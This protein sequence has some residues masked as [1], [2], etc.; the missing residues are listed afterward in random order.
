M[1]QLKPSFLS[2]FFIVLLSACSKPG[3]TYEFYVFGTLVELEIYSNSKEQADSASTQIQKSFNTLHKIWHAWEQGGLL[4]KINS[5]IAAGQSIKLEPQVLEFLQTIKNLSLKSEGYFNPGIGRLVALWGFHADTWRGPPPSY[6]EIRRFIEPAITMQS[7]KFKY[8]ELVT[9]D[10]R[11]A[12]DF[13]GVV[14]GY[15]LALAGKI[16]KEQG[17]KNAAVNAGGDLLVFGKKNSK[18]WNVGIKSPGGVI[19]TVKLEDGESIVSSG[20]YERKFTWQGKL[21]HHLINP[22][23]GQPARGVSAVTVIAKDPMLAD[24][25]ATA[26]LAAGIQNWRRIAKNF[27]L[28][29]VLLLGDDES[30]HMSLEMQSRIKLK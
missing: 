14:K 4:S 24:A 2:I 20:N 15:A 1:I 5:A 18:L 13:G 10:K 16:L 17:I 23:T 22:F 28:K 25:A 6:Q 27:G 29:Y 26:L 11:I 12:L 9:E 7:I 19:G 21:Y 8:N 30:L 3:F